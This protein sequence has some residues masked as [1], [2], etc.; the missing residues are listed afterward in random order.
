M[1]GNFSFGDY[2]KHEA[3]AW[4][5]EYLTKVLEIPEDRLWV[6]IYEK[7]D[8]AGD[9]WANEV[10]VPRDRIIKLGKAD[11]FWEHGSGPCG[12]VSYTHRDVYKRQGL[13]YV[14]LGSGKRSCQRSC[15]RT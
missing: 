5:W 6:T 12:P 3:T 11:N 14:R 13:C 2:F 7:D 10:G 4:A 9:I 8:E 1:L 15:R